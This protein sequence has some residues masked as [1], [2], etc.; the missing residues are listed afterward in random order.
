MEFKKAER[1]AVKLKLA[2]TGPS[3]SG[4]TFS[5]LKIAKGLGGKIAVIDTENGSASL[6]ADSAN[7][8]LYDVLELTPPFTT[9]RYIEAIQ[10]ALKANY[11]ILIIDSITHQWAAEGG[12][13]DRSNRQKLADPKGNSFTQ[14][15]KFT[16]EHEKFKQCILQSEM[17]IIATMRSK[18]EYGMVTNEKGRA[19]PQKLGMA[20]VQREGMEYEFTIVFDMDDRHHAVTSKDRTGLFTGDPFHPDESTGVKIKEW[21]LSGKPL[22]MRPTKE[23]LKEL[24]D[25]AKAHNRLEEIQ[26]R[27]T[28]MSLKGSNELSL[29]QFK[30][31]DEIIRRTVVAPP[32]EEAPWL[33]EVGPL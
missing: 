21:M 1:K 19:V 7:M 18:T 14:W 6:Y 23:Q 26:K 32:E 27:L 16:P 33:K 17:H 30:E 4:K 13:L 3:G 8:P 11:E 25:F 24:F 2:I 29:D 10:A 9:E 28:L 15:A 20:A 31:I 22:I 5:A 12:I